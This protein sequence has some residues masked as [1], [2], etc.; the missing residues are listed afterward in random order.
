[1]TGRPRSPADEPNR[2]DGP[3][4]IMGPQKAEPH[5]MGRRWELLYPLAS[6][7]MGD[8]Y[9]AK[10]AFTGKQAALK[11]LRSID[12]EQGERFRREAS[13]SAEIG[14]PQIVDIFD[15]DID[16]DTGSFY[17]AMELLEGRTLREVM[18]DERTTP[19]PSASSTTMF[20]GFKSRWTK[21]FA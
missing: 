1:M 9:V 21:P 8:I 3:P 7:G 4:Q 18:G 14:H 10:H 5:M 6:G 13:A 12:E 11:I 2:R 20:S 16:E 19:E 17:I 15:A